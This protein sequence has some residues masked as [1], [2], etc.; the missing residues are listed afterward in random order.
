MQFETFCE[1]FK[2]IEK[3]PLKVRDDL[4]V[5]DFL[6]ARQH[7]LVCEECSQIVDRVHESDPNK[8]DSTKMGL[9]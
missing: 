9:N 3:N 1:L 4:T 2:D 6:R 8:D 5:R 7:I